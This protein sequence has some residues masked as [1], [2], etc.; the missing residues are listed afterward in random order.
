MLGSATPGDQRGQFN[1]ATVQIL[2]VLS[3]YIGRSS[4]LGVT[5]LSRELNISKNMAYRALSTLVKEGFLVKDVSGSR[6]ELGFGVL[7]LQDLDADA[8][9]DVR[10]FCA[11]FL[12]RLHKITGE[13][14]F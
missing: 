4:S 7:W 3:A 12:Q 2:Q 6:Y 8:Q 5:E 11:P 9:F 1:K 13:S 10:A 14:I